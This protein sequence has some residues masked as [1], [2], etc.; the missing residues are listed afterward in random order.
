MDAN[1]YLKWITFECKSTATFLV[2]ILG[3]I[4]L[5]AW[6]GP[7]HAL[8]F[9]EA[10]SKGSVKFGEL[11]EMKGF[12]AK[13]TSKALAKLNLT[14]IKVDGGGLTADVQLRK[15]RWKRWTPSVGQQTGPDK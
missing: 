15:K 10:V 3:A 5:T 7:A 11:D 2:A 9:A 1:T 6:S 8:S 12:L 13:A 14:N 4:S